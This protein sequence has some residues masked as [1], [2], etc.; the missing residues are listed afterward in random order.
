MVLLNGRKLESLENIAEAIGRDRAAI[1]PHAFFDMNDACTWI[2]ELIKVWGPLNGLVHSAGI[3][4]VT[5]IRLAKQDQ[6]EREWNL[7]VQVPL[8]LLQGF[9]KRRPKNLPGSVVLVSSVMGL[10]GAPLQASYSA[11]K[12]AMIGLVRSAALELAQE[13]IR[14]N[15]VAPGCVETEM[16]AS[17][18]ETL[19]DEQ[20]SQIVASH[21]L[22]LGSATDVANAIAFL[23]GDTARWVTGT[24][25][26]VDGG[27]SAQ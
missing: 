11:A 23:L 15:A 7:H 14:V 17:F 6:V 2:G 24:T 18:K 4:Y 21:P 25:L 26:V 5:P 3:R 22:G 10:V 19:T 8:G 1:V 9:R 20:F 27:Y 16:L 13:R 12:S